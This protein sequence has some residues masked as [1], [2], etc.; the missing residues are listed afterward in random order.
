ME[1]NYLLPL[2]CLSALASLSR[3]PQWSWTLHGSHWV[4]A[5]AAT[6]TA[7]MMKAMPEL[8]PHLKSR[9]KMVVEVKAL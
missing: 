8:A 7:N 4:R 9:D 1:R 2:S 3:Q 5:A 6:V